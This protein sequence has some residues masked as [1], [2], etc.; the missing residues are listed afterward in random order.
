MSV[1]WITASGSSEISE[2]LFPVTSTSAL[3]KASLVPSQTMTLVKST[4]CCGWASAIEE[5]AKKQQTI[6]L[7]IFIPSSWPVIISD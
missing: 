7:M 5:T 3:R 6:A 1:D 4:P 2:I